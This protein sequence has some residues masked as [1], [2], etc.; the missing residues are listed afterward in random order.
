VLT[1]LGVSEVSFSPLLFP[2]EQPIAWPSFITR[3]KGALEKI[4]LGRWLTPLHQTLRYITLPICI[5]SRRKNAS[6]ILGALD[7]LVPVV[8]N[9]YLIFIMSHQ[10]LLSFYSS[11][12]QQQSVSDYNIQ[13]TIIQV[14][15]TSVFS[16]SVSI[17]ISDLTILE[18]I[19]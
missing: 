10:F 14:S 13:S 3:K 4:C 15:V 11:V 2:P 18:F 8:S 12:F 17:T 7:S 1:L 6:Q 5:F 9:L 19:L 16:P